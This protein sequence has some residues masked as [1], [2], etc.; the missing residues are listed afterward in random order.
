MLVQ[1]NLRSTTIFF[2]TALIPTGSLIGPR[3]IARNVTAEDVTESLKT[4]LLPQGFVFVRGDAKEAVLTL[5]RGMVRQA[6]V[7]DC[8]THVNL[9]HVVMELHFRYK[10]K[11]EGLEVSAFEIAVGSDSCGEVFPQATP[12]SVGRRDSTDR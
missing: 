9:V 1:M 6:N 2:L 10:R 4:K 11:G 12:D 8:R 5:D 3:V 7:F